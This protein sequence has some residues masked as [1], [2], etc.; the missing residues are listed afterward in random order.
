MKIAIRT[1]ASLYMGTGHLMRCLTLADEVRREGHTVTFI[2]R[3]LPGNLCELIEKKGYH[4]YRLPF[5]D[6]NRIQTVQDVSS[7]LGA[8]WR[9]DAEQTISVLQEISIASK[10]DW[11]VVD[12]YALDIQWERMMRPYVKRIMV[13]DDLANRPHDCDLLLDQN[14]YENMEQRYMGLVPETCKLLLGPQYALLRPEFREARKKL[15]PRDGVVRR[16]LIFF[17]GTDPTNET[18]KAIEAVRL[19]NRYDIEV[20]VVVGANNPH[21]DLVKKKCEALPNF[22]YHCQV[23]NM[24]ELMV[25]ADLAIGAGGSTTWER[26]CLGLPSILIAV[27]SNQVFISKSSARQNIDVFLGEASQVTVCDIKEAVEYFLNNTF[28]SL[29][30]K[31]MTSIVDGQGVSRVALVLLSGIRRQVCSQ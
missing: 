24:A 5:Q 1:D 20:D 14:L 15:R 21:R 23:D 8:T 28:D 2:C 16:I 12:H 10:I 25:K 19:L 7:W 6:K 3:E 11:L 31:K 18:L 29:I 4:V 9:E 13:I 17:G 26:Y 30:H 22:H 27:A